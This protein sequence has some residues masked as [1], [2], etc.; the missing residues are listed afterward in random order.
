MAEL[1]A[2]VT[3]R[4]K[5]GGTMDVFWTVVTIAVV[6]ALVCAVLWVFVIAPFVVPNRRPRTP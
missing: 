4:R 3:I 5:R 2:T 6:A 1:V